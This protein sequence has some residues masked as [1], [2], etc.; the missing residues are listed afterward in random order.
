M[1]FDGVNDWLTVNDSASLD[2]VSAMTLEAWVRPSG[3]GGMW[4][5]VLLKE[6]PGG[7]VYA[8]YAN[9][10]TGRPLGQ[11]FIGSE[12]NA[13][14]TASLTVDTWSHLAATFDGANLRLYVNGALVATT[15]VAGSM[16]AST[17]VLRIGGNSVWSEWFAGLIDE[18]RIYNR[19]LTQ[20]E[21]QTDMNRAVG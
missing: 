1:S 21:I 13:V 18:V 10:D 19:A 7:M 11:V 14:G 16:A 8:L 17:G 2:L 4:R 6:R 5:T 20:S 15:A 9:Q 3:L 12:R